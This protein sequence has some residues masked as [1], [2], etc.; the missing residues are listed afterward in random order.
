MTITRYLIIDKINEVYLKIEADADIRRELGEYFTF[1]V[2]GYKFMP[3]FRNRV[4]DGKIRLFAYAT[5][6][7]YAGLY[8]YIIDWCEKN[9]I[10]IVDGTKIKDVQTNADDVTRFLKA[11]KIPKIE[12]RDYQRE[13]FVHSITK[14]RCLLLS[15]TASGKSL[16]IYLMLIYNLLRLKE[17]KQDKILIIVPTTSLVEQ[18][19]KDFKDYGYNSDRNVHRIYQ[20]HDKDTTKR[21]VISTWQSIYNLPKKWFE[22]YG[23]V[24]GD[25][26]HLFKA[27]SLTKIMSKLEKCKYRVGLTGT[28]DGTKTHKLVLEGLFGTVNKVVS[29]SE[30][31]EK[32]QLANLKIFCLILQ[33]DKQVRA[34]MFGKT[35][36][37]EMDYLVSNEKRNKYIRNLVTG[38]Q[39]NT[40]V[41]FQYVEKHGVILQKLIEE[42]SDKQVFF[43][44]G[45]VA[46]EER[47]KIRFITE[48]SEG[49]II[50][51]SYGTFSTGINIRNLHNIVFASPS[52]SR[53]RNLQSIGRGLRLKDN[54][55]DATLYD[56]ADDLTHNEKEN[57]TL[58]HFRERINIYN[59]ED[60]EYE[61]H[62]VELK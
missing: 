51:A 45:G 23:M 35:Y 48:K 21:V 25:E 4:W 30:L 42:K 58:A 44:Y 40:L 36:Q 14:S 43:V 28:L 49:A 38:L 5:G 22:Q 53:I 27:V 12:I 7:I 37:E 13:A 54:D 26:A 62:N 59:E 18:L 11:L 8:P 9:N 1:E 3:A 50:V 16:I 39:G 41:L 61:I 20:G 2:P 60:F 33:H 15:P 47:E 29:T 24:V 52:K 19:Y 32:K 55:S 6:K 57:Y 56:I 17:K 10:Q 46:A 34:D 31:Q